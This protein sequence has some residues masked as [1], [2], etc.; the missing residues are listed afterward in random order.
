MADMCK[1]PNSP[2]E[3]PKS[4]LFKA[5]PKEQGGYPC[6]FVKQP[7]ELVSSE[8]S[9]CLQILREPHLI[10]CCGHNYCRYCI[11][12]V[13]KEGGPCPLCNEPGFT[14]LHNKGLQRALNELQV[15]CVHRGSGCE[16]TGELGK[17]EEH[18]NES[19]D[20]D[21]QLQGCEFVQLECVH[22]C[23]GIFY[24]S[25]IQ[26]H[27][28]DL[29]PQRP[30]SCDYC[31]DY[32]SI[33]AD[34]VYRHWQVCKCYPLSC[35]NHCMV[36]A[37]ERQHLEHHLN[38]ECPLKEIECEF[39]Y[40]GCEVKLLRKDMPAHLAEEHVQ[41]ASLLATMNQRFVEELLEKDKQISKLNEEM[42][43]HSA[44]IR[45]EGRHEI[46][47]LREENIILKQEVAALKAEV[48]CLKQSLSQEISQVRNIEAKQEVESKKG[49]ESLEQQIAQLQHQLEQ[50][51][52]SQM[53]QCYAVQA[54]IGLFPI[55]FTLE[56]YEQYT[57]TNADWQS[58]PFYSHLQGYKI[59]LIVNPNGHS[60][61]RG[62]HVSVYTCLMQGEFD[63]QLQWPFR[64]EITIQLLNQLGDKNHATGTIRFTDRTPDM[65]TCRV[66]DA[67]R[68]EKGWGQQK[69]IAHTDLSFNFV[70]NRQYLK[71]DC[72]C[73]RMTGIKL[74]K[75]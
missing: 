32:S 56:N 65:Y 68:A 24:R 2:V 13:Q 26:K 17:L 60:T 71:D 12:L 51:K 72:L 23:G 62:T 64:G 33:H 63:H 47:E 53:R 44:L 41:H 15:R 42:Q 14:V 70:K 6:E 9:I 61:A 54:Y 4:M 75:M 16:W 52:L 40:A 66:T 58:P 19:P 8:C 18:L 34:V 37:I 35:P 1:L 43:I 69:F 39:H 59:C 20:A 25:A 11:G 21:N 31:R 74:N 73:F 67:E 5:P 3:Q 57:K 22:G 30:Y 7:P 29:C 10:S 28:S 55:E 45:E 36:Y 50:S 38:T 27:Q 48:A 49:D 46:D